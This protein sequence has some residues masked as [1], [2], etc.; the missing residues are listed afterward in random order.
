MKKKLGYELYHS[1]KLATHGSRLGQRHSD[2]RGKKQGNVGIY[3]VI[4]QIGSYL[5]SELGK[6]SKGSLLM[7]LDSINDWE[8]SG[9]C[10]IGLHALQYQERGKE[11]KLNPIVS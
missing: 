5:E 2:N 10:P 1:A 3:V 7:T 11:H 9:K 8:Q 6:A 4:E